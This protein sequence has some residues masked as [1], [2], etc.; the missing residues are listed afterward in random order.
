VTIVESINQMRRVLQAGAAGCR[1]LVCAPS[2][3]ACDL[4]CQRLAPASGPRELLRLMS[5]Q[6]SLAD[7]PEA[8]RPYCRWDEE[9]R[10]FLCPKLEELK[11]FEII[12]TTCAMA[13]KLYNFGFE[14]GSF[15]AVVVDEAGHAW[16][17]EVVSAFAHLLH[18]SGALVLAGDPRQLGPVTHSRPA[19]DS[20]LG[21]SM[22]ERLLQEPLFARS[23]AAH[24]LTGGYHSGCITK[25]LSCYRCHPAIIRVPNELFYDGELIDAS[26]EQARTLCGWDALLAP[27]FPV[28]FHGVDGCN[29]REGNSP[30]WFN[31]A[32]V[33][34]SMDYVRRLIESRVAPQDIGIIAPYQKQVQ[35]LRVALNR[36]GIRGV[37]VGSCEQFQGQERRV[38]IVTTVRTAPDLVAA[39]TRFNLGF[40]ANEKRMNVAMTRAKALLIVIGNTKLLYVD[41]NWKRFIDYCAEN[42]ALT[43]T[44]PDSGL[45]PADGEEQ[46]E[47]GEEQEEGEEEGEGV[48]EDNEEDLGEELDAPDTL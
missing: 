10:C 23:E 3:A 36:G 39:D 31:V 33:E 1:M 43:G 32:E 19:I 26:G 41:P 34:Q 20:G 48:V 12:V 14:R 15:D 8:V 25:L 16:E 28:I 30:S 27:R 24:P 22:L 17:P 9:A 42:G 44:P 35:K 11:K 40:V 6:R 45:V 46:E 18:A 47:G 4:L 38:I 2:N 21:T 5:F 37:T 7:V 13:G 29:A